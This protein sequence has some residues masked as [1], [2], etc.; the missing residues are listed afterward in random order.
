MTILLT[1]RKSRITIYICICII[2]VFGCW[3]IKQLACPAPEPFKNNKHI[4]LTVK[5]VSNPADVERGL[6]FRKEPLMPNE[7]MLFDK[8]S[9]SE[10][11]FWMKNTY[12]PLDI[13]FLDDE[14][15]VIDILRNMVPGDLTIRR[16]NKPWRYAVEVNPGLDI[17]PGDIINVN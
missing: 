11:G 10:T 12:I 6:M 17:S 7:G 14:Y 16:I 5:R 9:W 13:I 2:I 3:I 1:N 15:I 4:Q 8:G